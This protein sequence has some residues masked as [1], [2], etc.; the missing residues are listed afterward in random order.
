VLPGYPGWFVLWNVG[1]LSLELGRLDQA[2]RAFRAL[3]RQDGTPAY[4]QLAR[5][6]ERT[7][8]PAEA[9]EAYKFVAYAWRHADPELQPA[10]EEARQAVTR[11]S[12]LGARLPH[13]Q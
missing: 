11:L 8:R 10:V 3:W 1:Q 9:L 7:G 5:M 13:G 2:E 12:P 6:L 4:L